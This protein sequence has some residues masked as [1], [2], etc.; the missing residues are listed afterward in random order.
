MLSMYAHVKL[1]GVEANYPNGTNLVETDVLESVNGKLQIKNTAIEYA[2]VEVL[3]VVELAPYCQVEGYDVECETCRWAN[4]CLRS[5][6][7]ATEFEI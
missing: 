3:Q 2:G 5:R 6:F 4:G 7:Q 1:N